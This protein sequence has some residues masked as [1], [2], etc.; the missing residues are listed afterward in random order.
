MHILQH[1]PFEG[2]GRILDWARSHDVR[3]QV[4]RLDLGEFPP[5]PADNEG[6][7]IM[8]GPMN[9]YEDSTYPWLAGEKV[10]LQAQ[11]ALRV[12]MLGICLGAQLLSVALGFRVYKN[13]V[14]EIGW[15]PVES[16]GGEAGGGR[17]FDGEATVLHWHGDTFDLP[18]GAQRLCQTA[19]CANQGFVHGSVLGLQFHLEAG[20]PECERM[21]HSCAD[22]LTEPAPT[23][24]SGDK[25]LSDARLYSESASAVLYRLLDWHFLS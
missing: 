24:H 14:K 3:T 22:E 12:P 20:L 1:V 2:P 18:Q 4:Y 5:E 23:I 9:V 11:V 16:L 15:M 19:Y 6:L 21:V 25:I 7:C 17:F 10:Y 13:A 8:G